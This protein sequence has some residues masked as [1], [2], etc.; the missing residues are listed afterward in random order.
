LRELLTNR[1]FVFLWL[2]QGASGLGGTFVAFIM[3]W[4]VYEMTGSLVAM[5]SMWIAF[6]LPSLIV[7]LWSG[8]YLDRWDRKTVMIY[9]EWLRAF[10]FL[11]P[12]IMFSLGLL[13]VWHL[14]AAAIISGIAEPLFRPA[15]MAYMAGILPKD[16]LQKA[17]S[18]LEGTLQIFTLIGPPIGGLV[19]Q[20]LGAGAVLFAMVG[21]MGLC[22]LLLVFIPGSRA[23]K[24][25]VKASWF[26]QFK[27]GLQF[28]KINPVLLWIGLLLMVYNFS[29]GAVMPL[30]L[31]YVTDIL[32]GSA[33]QYGLFTSSFSLGMILASVWTGMR[34]EPKNR[35][36]VML[37]AT[38]ISG[39]F[40]GLLGWV[41]HFPLAILCVVITGFFII[42]FNVNNTTLYQKKVPDELMG[43]VFAVRIFLSRAG[44]PVGALMGG[45]F[46]EAWGIP[47][48][49]VLVGGIIV[50][51]SSIAFFAPVFN[52]LND[53]VVPEKTEAAI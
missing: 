45:V 18:L 22:G 21:M 51:V 12:A 30:F 2:G 33:F 48:L 34:K 16:H 13:Q 50:A 42:I 32:G 10:A 1:A 26:K 40:M 8:P 27:E 9:S 46:A 31:P 53:T 20:W 35:R 6:M 52:N 49:F 5:G 24:V 44:M 37:G 7:Q 4:L 39:V 15:S 43:R 11:I 36:I 38:M 14:F 47:A 25:E 3:S 41:S 28:Y 23:R 17:N 29:S 19:F